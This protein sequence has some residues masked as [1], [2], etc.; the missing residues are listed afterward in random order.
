MPRIKRLQQAL[1]Q[2]RPP[3]CTPSGWC[4]LQAGVVFLPTSALISGL[5]L[6]IAITL[7]RP[8]SPYRPLQR[9]IARALLVLA[10][11][12]VLG[13][14]T[15]LKPDLAAIGLFN[16][17]PFFWFFLAIE[18][19]LTTASSRNRVA[20]WLIVGT[21]PVI[22]VGLLQ[23]WLGWSTPL[24]ALGGLLEWTMR[25]P[26]R[27]TGIFDTV[28]GTAGWL[29]LCVPFL[30]QRLRQPAGSQVPRMLIL[31]LIGLSTLTLLLTSS[32]S[33]LVMLPVVLLLTAKWRQVPWLLFLLGIYALLAGLTLTGVIGPW[34]G[35]QVLVP[36]LLTA[37]LERLIDPSSSPMQAP[38][39]RSSLYPLALKL[40]Q[41]SPWLGIGENG[42]RTLYLQGALPLAANEGLNHSHS[43]PLE[44]ALSH[45][46]PALALLIGSLGWVWF[47][48]MKHWRGHPDP[49]GQDRAWLLAAGLL[50]WLHL[51][52]IPAYD[53]RFNMLGWMIAAALL[54]MGNESIS[55][56]DERG[57][58]GAC[59][60]GLRSQRAAEH[61][62]RPSASPQTRLPR[63]EMLW[64]GRTED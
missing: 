40:M 32:R 11:G 62:E 31:G 2:G 15:A 58:P 52:D 42:F 44:F 63:P 1:N 3:G 61:P 18:P 36:D 24:R 38:E 47:R 29:I 20:L 7:A 41:E 54:A 13:V 57:Q 59:P 10:A 14:S 48:A 45:G 21:V 28:N 27:A 6:L 25:F 12:M 51:W 23:A 19:Y 39:V 35:S 46:L 56:D 50:I 55:S 5:S 4:W 16:W 22:V 49:H 30:L 8:Q 43:L 26:E 37:K 64:P 9:P 17:L 34:P 60:T 53:S 33:A